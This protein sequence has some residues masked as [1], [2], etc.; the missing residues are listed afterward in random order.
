MNKFY[1]IKLNIDNNLMPDLIIA[2][3]DSPPTALLLEDLPFHEIASGKMNPDWKALRCHL[4]N[5]RR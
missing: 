3:F 5:K 2:E 1:N 4:N